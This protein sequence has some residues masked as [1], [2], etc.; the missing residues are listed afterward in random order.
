M[1]YSTTHP[2]KTVS[3]HALH[4]ATPEKRKNIAEATNTETHKMQ[5]ADGVEIMAT[6]H[7]TSWS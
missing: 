7:C 2:A 1:N 5:S 6:S 4:W 3:V